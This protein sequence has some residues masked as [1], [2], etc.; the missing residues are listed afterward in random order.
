M[1]RAEE[2]VKALRC[3][4]SVPR[5]ERSC[6]GCKYRVLDEYD[7]KF[8]CPPDIEIDG[9]KY[10]E[11]CDCDQIV[12]DAADMIEELQKAAGNAILEFV[13]RFEAEYSRMAINV[14]EFR[15]YQYEMHRLAETMIKEQ[16]NG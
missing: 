12:M 2:I 1:N 15:K 3:S 13:T 4:A 8:P 7:G 5:A 14:G 6:E 11:G 10:Y 16:L 9:K